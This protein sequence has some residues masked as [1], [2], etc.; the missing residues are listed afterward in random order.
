MVTARSAASRD[1]AL[2]F[3]ADAVVDAAGADAVD[4]V[5]EALGESADVVFD[6]V[7]DQS[8]MLQAIGMANKGGTVVMVGVPAGD[9]TIPLAMVQDSQVRIQGS[10]T[11]LPEDY[12]DAMEMLRAGRGHRSR[13]RDVDAAA[14][15]GGGSLPGRGQRPP[16]QGAA[17]A[18]ELTVPIGS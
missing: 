14:S 18:G 17:H 4:Q 9:V 3:G 11:Y 5:R 16:H 8:T 10:A 1:R 7:A 6:C 2:R 12:A 13:L 15:R